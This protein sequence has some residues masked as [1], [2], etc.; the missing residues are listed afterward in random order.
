MS[1]RI[2]LKTERNIDISI[3]ELWAYDTTRHIMCSHMLSH[4]VI[5]IHQQRQCLEVTH[6]DFT[7]NFMYGFINNPN[8]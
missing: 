7:I 1:L 6:S 4:T 8:K 5:Q 2:P 3:Q